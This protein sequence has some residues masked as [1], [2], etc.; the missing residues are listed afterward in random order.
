[1]A[2][3]GTQLYLH[4]TTEGDLAYL[5]NPTS[6]EYWWVIKVLHDGFWTTPHREKL[7]KEKSRNWDLRKPNQ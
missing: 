7:L 2:A 1:M 4:V 5:E 6:E 3:A